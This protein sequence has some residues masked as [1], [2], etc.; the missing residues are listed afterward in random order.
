MW[1]NPRG[2]LRSPVTTLTNRA[3]EAV[4]L[5]LLV[6]HIIVSEDVTTIRKM[7]TKGCDFCVYFAEWQFQLDD[8]HVRL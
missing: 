1:G 8:S 2:E 4:A 6:L 5:Q 3:K 7:T